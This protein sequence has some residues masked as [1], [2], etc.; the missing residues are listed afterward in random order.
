MGARLN[1]MFGSDIGHWDVDDMDAVL[2]HAYRMVEKNMLDGEQFR[3]WVFDNA[4]R[5]H[6]GPNR[7]FFK[8][9]VVESAAA[10]VL[11]DP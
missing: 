2:L 5:L 1:A 6:G 3:H 11:E 10:A 9:T 7:Q 4:V 8:G